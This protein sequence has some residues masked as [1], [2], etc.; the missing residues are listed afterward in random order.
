[1][2]R[3]LPWT[4]RRPTRHLTRIPCEVVRERDFRLVADRIENLSATGFLVGP[5]DPVLTGERL[6]FA[7][8]V[9]LSR[10]FID[11]EATV[12]RVVHGR[13]PGEYSRSLGLHF[14]HVDGWA[15]S[16]LESNLPFLPISPPD[17]RTGRR[18]TNT[19]LRWLTRSTGTA[20]GA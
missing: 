15:R 1:M 17:W 3:Y 18:D 14:D 9:P 6:L 13:R 19:S 4:Q 11:G 16:W 5:A 2:R 12:T 7:F 10:R 8:R 20:I